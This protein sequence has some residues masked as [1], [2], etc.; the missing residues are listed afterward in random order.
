[1]V[2]VVSWP[3]LA[4]EIVSCL[5]LSWIGIL[6]RLW[7]VYLILSFTK[8]MRLW[9]G[10]RAWKLITGSSCYAGWGSQTTLMV[11]YFLGIIHFFVCV[12]ALVEPSFALN[13]QFDADAPVEVYFVS[14]YWVLTVGSGDI[15]PQSTELRIVVI[16]MELVGVAYQAFMFA[17][18]ISFSASSSQSAYVRAFHMVRDHIV[19]TGDVAIVRELEAYA[20]T[21][22]EETR[23]A[24][25]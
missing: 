2:R 9:R 4:F 12:T 22:F 19:S 20:Q 7:W 15:A 1:V 23:R 18:V 3:S 10:Y 8:I 13:T 21:V 11:I 6:V 16:V 5:P 24:P 17:R 14:F 25:G